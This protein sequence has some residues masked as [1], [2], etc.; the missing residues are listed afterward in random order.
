[1]TRCFSISGIVSEA[2]L[3]ALVALPARAGDAM[4]TSG[5]LEQVGRRVER[6]WNYLPAVTCTESVV[7]DKLNGK[8]K[9][10]FERRSAYDYLILLQSSGTQISVDENRV[11]K[12]RKQ[13]KGDAAL[14]ST[15]GFSI[16]AL[17]FHPIFQSDYEFRQ[18]PD[19]ML[20]GKLMHRISFRHIKGTRSPSVLVVEDRKYPLDWRGTAWIDPASGAIARIDTGLE[21]PMDN[22]GLLRLDAQVTYTDIHFA[23][24]PDVY[25]LP[26]LAT[27]EA[28]TKRQ[29]WRNT[30]VFTGYR[31]FNVE[32]NVTTEAPK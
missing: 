1:M 16:L 27:V 10:L 12:E 8:G 28:E 29:L 30:H 2:L 6:L 22:L 25:W 5:L 11:E 3:A 20:D 23:G 21:G 9:V 18:L 4:A 14:L 15:T 17:I 32:T 19:E 31:R 26:T 13:K 24:A 7:Q